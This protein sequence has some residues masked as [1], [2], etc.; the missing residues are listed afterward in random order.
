MNDSLPQALLIGGLPVI[1]GGVMM[2]YALRT[3][4]YAWR[5]RRWPH[6]EGLVLESDVEEVSRGRRHSRQYRPVIVYSYEVEGVAY[7]NDQLGFGFDNFFG[8]GLYGRRADAER[9]ATG[10]RPGAPV[11]VAYDPE[12]PFRAVLKTG[13]NKGHIV[14]LLFGLFFIG[15]GGYCFSSLSAK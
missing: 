10:Y 15:L 14:S 4:L 9:F 8:D 6:V 2:A 12:N 7:R 13:L 5:S 11:S 3:G 1:V